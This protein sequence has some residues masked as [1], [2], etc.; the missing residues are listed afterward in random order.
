M[1]YFKG[2]GPNYNWEQSK[3]ESVSE[4]L[5]IDIKTLNDGGFQFYRSRLIRKVL[6]STIIQCL[7]VNS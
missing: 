6:E 5:G 2:D 3:V 7:D 4:F 1:K